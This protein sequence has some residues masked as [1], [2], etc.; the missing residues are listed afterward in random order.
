MSAEPKIPH[1][2]D[3]SLSGGSLHHGDSEDALD[4]PM[5]LQASADALAASGIV[6]LM[7]RILAKH[8]SARS[9]GPHVVSNGIALAERVLQGAD[10]LSGT[11]DRMAAPE[12]TETVQQMQAR[13]VTGIGPRSQ[14]ILAFLEDVKAWLEG[15]EFEFTERRLEL[16]RETREHFRE[17]D[18]SLG[19]IMGRTDPPRQDT[20]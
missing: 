9:T 3:R 14:R 13:G 17:I 5:Q 1:G 6:R 20:W 18:S 12:T 11:A 10:Y 2:L 8:G 7:N 16:A 15:E 4:L 19:E